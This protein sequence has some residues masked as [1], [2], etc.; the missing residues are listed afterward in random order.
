MSASTLRGRSG[1][2]LSNGDATARSGRKHIV[3]SRE[4]ERDFGRSFTLTLNDRHR[5]IAAYGIS[6]EWM[7]PKATRAH[8]SG[9]TAPFDFVPDEGDFLVADPGHDRFG[10]R[11]Q[12]WVDLCARRR[13]VLD[14]LLGARGADYRSGDIGL[15]KHP[16]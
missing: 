6:I 8:G 3:C 13:S 7:R 2:A 16:G 5:P 10:P 15:A 1:C 11:E 12:R 4:A 14:N 9:F